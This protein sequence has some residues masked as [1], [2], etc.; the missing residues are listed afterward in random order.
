MLQ[1]HVAECWVLGKII[2]HA[3]TN[4]ISEDLKKFFKKLNIDHAVSSLCNHQSSG[5]AEVCIIFVLRPTKSY[6]T[7]KDVT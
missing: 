3:G 7:N 6:K 5:Q 4:F 1:D 2:L